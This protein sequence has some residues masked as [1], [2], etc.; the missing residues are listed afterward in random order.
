MS[1]AEVVDYLLRYFD[2]TLA[3]QQEQIPLDPAAR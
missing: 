3:W 1:A 2:N